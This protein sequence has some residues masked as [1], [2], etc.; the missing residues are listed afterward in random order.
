MEDV[1]GVLEANDFIFSNLTLLAVVSIV[2]VKTLETILSG[3]Y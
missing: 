1:K 3:S 2:L